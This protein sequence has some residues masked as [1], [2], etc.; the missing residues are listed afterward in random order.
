MKKVTLTLAEKEYVIKSL[1]PNKA[2]LWREKANVL[3]AQFNNIGKDEK[4]EDLAKNPEN[5]SDKLQDNVFAFACRFPA[6]AR[7]LLFE[8]SPELKA[9]RDFLLENSDDEELLDALGE[10]VLMAFPF[11]G[12][13]RKVRSGFSMN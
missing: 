10:V 7:D 9:D 8:Y 12:L 1:N 11:G 2:D 6:Q 13:I 3:L 5:L 4:P